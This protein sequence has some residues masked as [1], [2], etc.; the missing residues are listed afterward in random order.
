M[1]G[2]RNYRGYR[3]RRQMNGLGLD[4]ST[5]WDEAIKEGQYFP[6]TRI[7]LSS[8]TDFSSK[9]A[10]KSSLDQDHTEKSQ[11]YNLS[12]PSKT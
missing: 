10:I 11:V 7:Q 6:I 5:R 2:Q 3:S 9:P 4:P 1:L 8:T 12:I